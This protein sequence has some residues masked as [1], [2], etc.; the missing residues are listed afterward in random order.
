MLKKPRHKSVL[1]KKIVASTGFFPAEEEIQ[2]ISFCTTG[3]YDENTNVLEVHNYVISHLDKQTANVSVLEK[4]VKEKETAL[5]EKVLR[6]IDRKNIQIEINK[7]KKEI[8]DLKIEAK[9][10]EYLELV[11]PILEEYNKQVESE[12]PHV[13]NGGSR[14]FNA[15]KLSA[16]RGCIQIAGRYA[17]LS[18]VM[19][20]QLLRGKCPYCRSDLINE[21]ESRNVCDSC[22][23]DEETMI[24]KS[25]FTEFGSCN[26]ISSNNYTNKEIFIK[27]MTCHQGKQNAEFPNDLMARVDDY[28][29]NNDIN[30]HLLYADGMRNIFKNVG[31]VE[32]DDVNL[33][34]Y[35]YAGKKL[36]DLSQYEI[37]LIADYDLFMPIYNS[38][39][40]EEKGSALNARYILY[41]LI[42]KQK[43]NHDRRDFQLPDTPLRSNDSIARRVFEVLRWQFTETG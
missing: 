26:P 42:V 21:D 12:G 43:I 6:I 30:K 13:W 1:D 16:I 36:P 37:N 3:M 8:D 17:P 15:K 14:D 38:I 24:R 10:K 29:K 5:T 39:K 23:F 22:G 32:Y 34:L 27:T 11:E 9:K 33:F 2:N 35:L 4:E 41:I 18:L 19:N 28:C 20:V 40:G 7:L 31:Y 25:K